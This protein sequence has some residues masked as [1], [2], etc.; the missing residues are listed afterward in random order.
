MGEY[1]L[2]EAMIKFSGRSKFIVYMP[3][4]PIKYGFRVYTVAAAKEPIVLS[5]SIYDGVKSTL[6][7]LIGNIVMPYKQKGHKLYMDRYYSTPKVYK[8]LENRGSE[9]VEHVW[10]I[11][12][13]SQRKSKRR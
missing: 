3:L 4:K 12:Y 7:K 8:Y 5:M 9:P 13:S 6:P 1:M 11:D 2:D 10:L